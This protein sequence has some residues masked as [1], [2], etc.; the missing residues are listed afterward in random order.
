MK[1]RLLQIADY[2]GMSVRAFEAACELQRGNISNMSENGAIGSDKLSKIIDS[3]PDIN[4]EW[5]ITGKGEM[6]KSEEGK[7]LDI[8]FYDSKNASIGIG[9]PLVPFEYI[10]G[11]GEDNQGI[12]LD[13]CER[14][15]IPEF[16]HLGAEFLCRV[17]GSSMYP[18]YS[19][20]DILA[21]KK[22]HEITFFQWGKIYVVDSAQGQMIKRVCEHEESE[23]IWLIS[24][25]REKLSNDKEKYAPF[26][27]RKDEIR[28]L[29]IVLGVIR[30]E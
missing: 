10:A 28:S 16:E 29:S 19:S 21:C 14:Y 20:G 13:E 30:M 25:N 8:Q 12:K 3:F 15:I 22:I 27:I 24:D 2:L 6:L 9:L 18:K 5:L 7:K 23:K 26:A 17:G 1:K 11:Y 4:P